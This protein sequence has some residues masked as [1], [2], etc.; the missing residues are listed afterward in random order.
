MRH[1]TSGPSTNDPVLGARILKV[2]WLR[3]LGLMASMVESLESGAISDKYTPA[4][5]SMMEVCI[6]YKHFLRKETG[7][8][9]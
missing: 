3:A 4:K 6:S 7:S 2:D 1:V 8:H 9:D 5:I